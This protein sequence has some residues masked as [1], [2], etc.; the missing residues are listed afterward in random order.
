MGTY[1]AKQLADLLPP[2][3]P[4]AHKYSRGKLIAV[5]G[6]ERYPGAACL[7]ACAS[8]RMGAGYTEVFTH[9][10]AIDLVR[11][12]SYSLV[13]RDSALLLDGAS[14][15]ASFWV[16]R[17]DKPCA[18]LIG[19]GF[20]AS[21]ADAHALVCEVL[22]RAQAPVLIDG[23]ALSTL[24]HADIRRALTLRF[25]CGL[26]TVVTPHAG[27]AKS[28]AKV[29]SLSDENPEA[30]ARLLSL[31][32]GVVVVLKGPD[33]FISEGDEVVCVER[34][35]AA[36]AKAGTGDVLAGMIGALL[37]QGIAAVDAAV[38]GVE[39]HAQAGILAGESLHP[40]SVTASDVGD[41]IPQAIRSLQEL[42]E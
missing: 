22:K 2:P 31:A 12:S 11:S 14:A 10:S 20:D 9:Y 19:S 18:V 17:P 1:T 13:V 39:I 4:Q 38:L 36:L 30:L 5:V 27:E 29:Y 16:S 7:A 25:E 41:F 32:Y 8:E 28:M 33:T 3:R 34:G 23:G 6:S 21:S 37:A 42:A 15:D 40:I 24:A 35:T 26:P